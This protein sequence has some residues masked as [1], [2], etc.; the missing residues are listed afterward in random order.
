MHIILL[1]GS[2]SCNRPDCAALFKLA[3]WGGD[4]KALGI[5]W[6]Y[7]QGG[8]GKVKLVGHDR[9]GIGIHRLRW[10][11]K[12]VVRSEPVSD[13]SEFYS[14][15]HPGRRDQWPHNRSHYTP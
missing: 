2:S 9:A 6:A 12:Y 15:H 8:V 11:R 3:R 5:W 10:A 14:L 4:I 13:M 1:T 7:I